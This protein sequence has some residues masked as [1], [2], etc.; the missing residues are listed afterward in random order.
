MKMKIVQ[1]EVGGGMIFQDMKNNIF[2]QLL[3]LE[4]LIEIF[5][6]LNDITC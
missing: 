3:K 4:R 5:V 1:F 6:C 2:G